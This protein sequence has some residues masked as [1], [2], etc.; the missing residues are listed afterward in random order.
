VVCQNVMSAVVDKYAPVD[1]IALLVMRR[2]I[3]D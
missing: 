1:D 2:A 3:T